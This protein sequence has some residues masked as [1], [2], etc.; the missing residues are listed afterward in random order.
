MQNGKLRGYNR[1]GKR[2]S[3]GA[4]PGVPL[5]GLKVKYTLY[6]FVRHFTLF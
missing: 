6:I 1:I 2:G 5:K 4:F 3:P